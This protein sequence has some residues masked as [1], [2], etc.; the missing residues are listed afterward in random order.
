MAEEDGFGLDFAQP[1]GDF[2]PGLPTRDGPQLIMEDLSRWLETDENHLGEH[3]PEGYPWDVTAIGRGY[4]L[5]NLLNA[6]IRDFGVIQNRIEV[7]CKKDDRVTDAS[8]EIV[9]PGENVLD[10]KIRIF[11]EFGNFAFTIAVSELTIETLYDG[12]II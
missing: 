8:V 4:N 5:R 2:L 1:N 11:S 3:L 7:E 9:S 12:R 10:I 6:K